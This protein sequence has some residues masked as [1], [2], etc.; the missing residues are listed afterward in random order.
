MGVKLTW[1][2]RGTVP[3][4]SIKIYRSATKTGEL[5]LI[6]TIAGTALSYEDTTMPTTNRVYWYSVASVLNGNETRGQLTPM[7]HFPDSGPGP[8]N[9]ILGDWEFGYFGEVTT[10]L[11]ALPTFD[12]VAAAGGFNKS[13][14]A[15]DTPTK[16]RKWV[17]N[18][19]IIYMPN[20][21][22]GTTSANNLITYKL[23]KPVNND[24]APVLSIGK[25]NYGFKVRVPNG[26]TLVDTTPWSDING[27]A[28]KLKSEVCALVLHHTNLDNTS[29]ANRYFKG[30]WR[31]GD[32]TAGNSSSGNIFL[33]YASATTYYGLRWSVYTTP[34]A[35]IMTSTVAMFL[36]YEL[37]FGNT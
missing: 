26:S 33:G 11:S 35:N 13:T 16:F 18:G 22:I 37:D 34:A 20:A 7:G 25:G 23:L 28:S 30:S 15:A 21:V 24:S 3:L 32:E 1:Q 17:I 36:V 19:K 8:K 29:E 9:I 14:N 4:D 31:Y 2:N 6:D 27:D 5:V 10:D 12:E